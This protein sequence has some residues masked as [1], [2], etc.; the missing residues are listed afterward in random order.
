MATLG[1]GRRASR[2]RFL[3]TTSEPR[4]HGEHT[5]LLVLSQAVWADDGNVVDSICTEFTVPPSARQ[6]LVAVC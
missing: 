5:F 2:A 1:H 6:N 4:F 3:G